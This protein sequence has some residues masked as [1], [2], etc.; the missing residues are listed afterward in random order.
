M[1][2]IL[3]N[4][5]IG[6]AV[7]LALAGLRHMNIL[8]RRRNRR[9][10]REKHEQW[11]KTM[12][13]MEPEAPPGIYRMGIAMDGITPIFTNGAHI[14]LAGVIKPEGDRF[15]DE[16]FRILESLKGRR[17]LVL[18]A[19]REQRMD[20]AHMYDIET[21]RSIAHMMLDRKAVRIDP[22]NPELPASLLTKEQRSACAA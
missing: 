18:P 16:A 9:I 15:G 11:L 3:E 19:W 12:A 17:I 14:R 5:L 1:S 8:R 7:I 21:G 20:H 6:A 13:R 10:E 2:P 22:K 4:I